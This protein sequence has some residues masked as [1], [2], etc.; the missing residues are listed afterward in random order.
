VVAEKATFR[1]LS[2]NGPDIWVGGAQG[3]LYHS[4]DAGGHWIQVKPAAGDLPLS[5]DIAAIE[6]TDPRHGKVTTA[7]GEVWLTADAGRTW[8]IQR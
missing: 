7:G 4:T 6:F 8:H 3:L 5:A 1:A 2:A